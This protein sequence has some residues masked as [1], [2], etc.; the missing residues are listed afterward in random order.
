MVEL[1]NHTFCQML[2]YPA[3]DHQR[4]WDN[5]LMHYVSAQN[6]NG[7]A[8]IDLAPNEGHIGRYPRLPLTILEG[9]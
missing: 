8:G 2:T 7:S 5:M 9:S 4:D 3:A 1:L 6:S